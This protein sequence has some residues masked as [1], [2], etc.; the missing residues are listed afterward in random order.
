V[1]SLVATVES[2]LIEKV[3]ADMTAAMKSRDAVILRTTRAIIAAVQEAS[4]A[5]PSATTL[6][7]DDVE[8]VIR[9]QAKRRVE[10]AEAFD[11]G[12]R[13]ERAAAE[14]DELA[15]LETYLPQGLGE[16][17]LGDLVD[18]VLETGGFSS[19]ADMGNAMKAVNAEVAGRADGR[20]VA[21]LVKARLAG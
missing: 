16:D 7:D 9:A 15:V 19:M 21:G 11:D 13:P 10:A 12:D 4:V 6:S 18:S 17:E 14:R 1:G 5:G 20:V 3:R 2:M 8:N